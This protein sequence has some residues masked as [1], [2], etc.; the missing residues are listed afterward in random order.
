[1]QLPQSLAT[2]YDQAEHIGS[3]GMG[4]VF[5]AF[6]KKLKRSVILKL[7]KASYLENRVVIKRFQR[8]ASALAAINHPNVIRLFKVEQTEDQ[9]CLVL[10]D[11]KGQNL[12]WTLADGPTSLGR[13]VA[14]VKEIAQALAVVHEAGLLHRDIK[15]DNVLLDKEG[16]VKLID[17]GLVRTF[18][19]E[20]AT[21]L[22]QTGEFVGTFAYLPPEVLLHE[23]PTPQSDLFQL[24]VLFYELLTG[25]MPFPDNVHLQII[26]ERKAKYTPARN[27]LPHLDVEI[28]ELLA[29]LLAIDKSERVSSANELIALL[30][31]WASKDGVETVKNKPVSLTRGVSS[32]STERPIEKRSNFIPLTLLA[33]FFFLLVCRF[34]PGGS[35]EATLLSPQRRAQIQNQIKA[36]CTGL[37]DRSLWTRERLDELGKLLKEAGYHDRLKVGKEA[38]ERT[39]ALVHIARLAHRLGQKTSSL[40]WYEQLLS[41]QYG[42]SQ[43]LGYESWAEE[44]TQSALSRNEHLRVFDLLQQLEKGKQQWQLQKAL[45]L[46]MI[47]KSEAQKSSDKKKQK[48]QQC[49]PQYQKLHEI[50]LMTLVELPKEEFLS[51]FYRAVDFVVSCGGRDSDAHLYGLMDI[52]KKR[53]PQ[54]H[55]IWRRIAEAIGYCFGPKVKELTIACALLDKAIKRTDSLDDIVEMRCFQS[56][57]RTRILFNRYQNKWDETNH[58]EKIKELLIKEDKRLSKEIIEFVRLTNVFLQ[59]HIEAHLGVDLA[60]K[61]E[62]ERKFHNIDFKKL[63]K[64]HH[65]MY[66]ISQGD[67]YLL[68]GKEKSTSNS[69]RKA[70]DAG[71]RYQR[72]YMFSVIMNFTVQALFIH[73]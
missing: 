44:Y 49:A 1:M 70:Y 68:K 21:V 41:R 62:L 34:F 27:H 71:A 17:F 56:Y 33:L 58:S 16:R 24:G 67:F 45:A 18:E 32:V 47:L 30:D 29:S 31:D 2:H 20:C 23:E 65:L 14:I 40:L 3:G 12:S 61:E 59:S 35:D 72:R 63:L 36:L 51:Y 37:K 69:Y 54:D 46:A 10:E 57:F 25:Q 6:D 8:E 4:V 53:N 60:N 19:E 13:A 15:P 66:Y 50:I 55:R 28:D 73:H 48:Q 5:R 42:E 26:H 7:L 43:A 52:V 38:Q 22:T 11:V 64:R 39:F 9:L